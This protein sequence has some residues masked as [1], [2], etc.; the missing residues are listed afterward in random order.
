MVASYAIWYKSRRGTWTLIVQCNWRKY[1]LLNKQNRVCSNILVI[2][3][4]L[5]MHNKV[6]KDDYILR[7]LFDLRTF[8]IFQSSYSSPIL[9][10][11]SEI[12]LSFLGKI[13]QPKPDRQ[14]GSTALGLYRI[15]TNIIVLKINWPIHCCI[16]IYSI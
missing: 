4:V 1:R 12:I 15:G 10:H 6:A 11:A 9:N 3:S 14:T 2:I 16:V 7:N 13:V 8:K 5:C